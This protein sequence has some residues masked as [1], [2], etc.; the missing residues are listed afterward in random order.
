[1]KE[2]I[3]RQEE[4]L[5]EFLSYEDIST[6]DSNEERGEK[7]LIFVL[8]A[9]GLI[10]A[11]IVASITFKFVNSKIVGTGH[12]E[13]VAT[14][15]KDKDGDKKKEDPRVRKIA[16]MSKGEL[17]VYNVETEKRFG[18]EINKNKKYSSLSWKNKDELSYSECDTGSCTINTYSISK[19]KIVDS[20][21]LQASDVLALKWSSKETN[22]AYLFEQNGE[23]YL[24][25]KNNGSFRNLGKFKYDAFKIDDFGDSTYIR[26]SPNDERILLVNTFTF[27]GEPTVVV[28]DLTGTVLFSLNKEIGNIPTSAFF[29][30]NEL[31]YFKKNNSLYVQS[32]G[33]KKS[34]QLSE[35]IVG[36]FDFKP[37]PD[38]TKIA[39]WTYD[40]PSGVTTIWVYDIGN[41]VMKRLRDQESRPL[42]IDD[43]LLIS[44][45]TPNCIECPKA[46]LKLKGISLVSL[47][48]KVVSDLL[49]EKNIEILATEEF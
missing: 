3:P 38:K 15:E 4:S 16:Y 45:Q 31:I 22:L 18:I 47:E 44:Y 46:D 17:F 10:I 14:A 12:A 20:F 25:L 36:A 26:F 27:V 48:T 11:G 7:I 24:T 2:K 19:K 21:E 13:L 5:Q 28:F 23:L 43:Q 49:K 32:L 1:M 42:W 35:R 40:W 30:S 9:V 8:C 41:E 34:R 33:E 37:S 29:M 39:Y 6:S